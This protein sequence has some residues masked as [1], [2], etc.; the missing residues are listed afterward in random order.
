MR[1]RVV[2]I[3]IVAGVVAIFIMGYERSLRTPTWAQGL[4][5]GLLLG[6]AFTLSPLGTLTLGAAAVVVAVVA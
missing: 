4:G 5:L 3:A 1:R 6:I 2:V